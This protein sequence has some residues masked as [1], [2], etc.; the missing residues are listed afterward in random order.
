MNLKE[1]EADGLVSR[2]AY[3]QI[4]PKVEYFLTE[5]GA[6]LMEVLGTLC[7]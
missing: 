1:L 2:N 3:A 5:C 4:P 6:S 7:A